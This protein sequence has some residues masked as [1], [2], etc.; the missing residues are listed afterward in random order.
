MAKYS[1][2]LLVFL[3]AISFIVG[4]SV[5]AQ[6]LEERREELIESFMQ[7]VIEKFTYEEVDAYLRQQEAEVLETGS[8]SRKYSMGGHSTAQSFMMRDYLVDYLEANASPD[9]LKELYPYAVNFDELPAELNFHAA[10]GDG[11]LAYQLRKTSDGGWEIYSTKGFDNSFES[12][13][14][15]RI[16]PENNETSTYTIQDQLGNSR[17]ISLNTIAEYLTTPHRTEYRFGFFYNKEGGLSL[18]INELEGVESFRQE[19][20]STEEV[21][22]ASEPAE[23]VVA[24]D[25]QSGQDLTS[26]YQDKVNQVAQENP[27]TYQP[28][29]YAIH[30]IDGNGTLELII[31]E[32]GDVRQIYAYHSQ[33][34]QLDLMPEVDYQSAERSH[35]VIQDNGDMYLFGSNGAARSTY[36]TYRFNEAG[37]A[38]ETVYSID[39]NIDANPDRPFSL[40]EDPNTFYTEEEMDQVVE[41]RWFLGENGRQGAYIPYHPL[42]EPVSDWIQIHLP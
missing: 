39:M 10:G 29:G 19:Y 7:G 4:P 5:G 35:L 30:D 20:L 36:E 40:L 26:L 22:E 1:K 42:D 17:D 31:A 38:L 37:T 33:S 8:I 34:G 24:G 12:S 9:H 18:L 21:T 23:L 3:I 41:G 13:D 15:L 16:L 14:T 25:N 2:H 28:Y 6:S 32:A 27:N 11:E